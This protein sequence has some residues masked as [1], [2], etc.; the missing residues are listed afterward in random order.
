MKAIIL[1]AG[2]GTRIMKLNSSIPKPLIEVAGKPMIIWNIEL[3]KR[4]GVKDIAINTH[5]MAD[6]IKEYLGGGEK[7]GVNL[8]YS[9]EPELLGTSGALNNFKNFLYE[10]FFVLYSDIISNMNL[11][12]LINF[13]EGKKSLATLVI[14]ETDHPEDSDIVKIDEDWKIKD[15]FYKPGSSKYGN[16]ASSALYVFEPEIFDFIHKGKSYFIRDVLPEAIKQGKP[17]YGYPTKE[18]I[19]DAGT[20]ERIV[21]IEKIL[22][23]EEY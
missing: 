13:H 14:H 9:Y 5:H 7:F 16:F 6:K 21:K 1:S 18:L 10:K 11:E 3:L 23:K 17:I 19:E 2:K 15:V 4:Y 12:S 20:P 22:N 8:R